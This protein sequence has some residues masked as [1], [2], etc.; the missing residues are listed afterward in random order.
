LGFTSWE[1]LILCNAQSQSQVWEIN[2]KGGGMGTVR[3]VHRKDNGKWPEIV[4]IYE[5]TPKQ[6]SGK[7]FDSTTNF[8]LKNAFEF[9]AENKSHSVEIELARK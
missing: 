8:I 9:L 3:F 5:F 1:I 6:G 7:R 4:A 2:E